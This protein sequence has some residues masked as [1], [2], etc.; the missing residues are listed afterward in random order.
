MTHPES[1]PELAALTAASRPGA[2]KILQY[3]R[4]NPG[5]YFGQILEGTGVPI[6]SL[7]RHLSELEDHGFI[8]GDI[9]AKARRGRATRYDIDA[10][11]IGSAL[12]TLRTLL[13]G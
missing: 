12:D 3:L 4:A 11:R 7:T 8:T 10:I 6:G 9:P 5:S 13:L 2:L 1:T